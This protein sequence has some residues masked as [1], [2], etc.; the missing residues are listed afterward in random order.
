MY[1]YEYLV[2][3][4]IANLKSEFDPRFANVEKECLEK[5]KKAYRLGI[6]MK[7]LK[8]GLCMA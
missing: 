6:K 8:A 7:T 5:L 2:C 3:G 1:V 4:I